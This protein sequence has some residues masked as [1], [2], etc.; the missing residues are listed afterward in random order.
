MFKLLLVAII[1]ILLCGVQPAVAVQIEDVR[2]FAKKFSYSG[3]IANERVNCY[4]SNSVFGLTIEDGKIANVIEGELSDPTIKVFVDDET[5]NRII[6]SEDP[7]MAFKKSIALGKVRIEGVG[8]NWF[9]YSAL[10]FAIKVLDIFYT[11]KGEEN[12]LGQRIVEV[13]GTKQVVDD[14][15]LIGYTTEEMQKFI[16]NNAEI[17]SPSAGILSSNFPIDDA[18]KFM[19]VVDVTDGSTVLVFQNPDYTFFAENRLNPRCAIV[20]DGDTF[21]VECESWASIAG[22]FEV[23]DSMEIGSV[24]FIRFAPTYPDA[25]FCTVLPQTGV[26]FNMVYDNPFIRGK[27]ADEERKL[28]EEWRKNHEKWEREA[29]IIPRLKISKEVEEEMRK[30]G[31]KKNDPDYHREASERYKQKIQEELGEC[32][33]CNWI[34]SKHC[35][36]FIPKLLKVELL[37]FGVDTLEEYKKD[38]KVGEIIGE[39]SDSLDLVIFLSDIASAFSKGRIMGTATP[40]AGAYKETIMEFMNVYSKAHETSIWIEVEV[41]AWKWLDRYHCNESEVWERKI[42]WYKPMTVKYLCSIGDIVEG[43]PKDRLIAASERARYFIEWIYN[44]LNVE[45][46]G[47]LL[48]SLSFQPVCV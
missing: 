18:R 11:G 48:V 20:E 21:E 10:N 23:M 35:I 19:D 15:G 8:L 3:F 29:K 5:L 4:V 30:D 44:E 7:A 12:E 40:G 28:E 37:P 32:E 6:R 34:T 9:K 45:N 2:E 47:S 22:E 17:L 46:N 41:V 24:S 25:A 39:I 1:L 33:E 43:S 13:D 38:K 14:L 42:A 16:E 26:C 31:W 27:N 36:V